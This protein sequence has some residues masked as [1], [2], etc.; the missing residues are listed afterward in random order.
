MY[1]VKISQ[2]QILKRWN[3]ILALNFY[4]LFWFSTQWETHSKIVNKHYLVY[5]A[6]KYNTSRVTLLKTELKIIFLH[7]THIDYAVKVS[8]A[9]QTKD[10]GGPDLAGGPYFTH[11]CSTA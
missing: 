5:L 8:S 2:N 7:E 9:D 4:S 10:L 1:Y 6:Y 3:K 11:P